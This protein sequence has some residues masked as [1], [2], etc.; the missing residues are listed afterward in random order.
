MRKIASLAA[1]PLSDKQRE[2]L[3]ARGRLYTDLAGV[4]FLDYSGV[5]IQVIGQGMD[6]RIIKLRVRFPF[7]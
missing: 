7:P 2:E 6:Q 1:H 4:R 5:L 3:T